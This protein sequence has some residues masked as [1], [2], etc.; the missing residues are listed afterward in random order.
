MPFIVQQRV[1]LGVQRNSISIIT[2]TNLCFDSTAADQA[3]GDCSFI[4]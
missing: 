4:A 2:S 1:S 3:H